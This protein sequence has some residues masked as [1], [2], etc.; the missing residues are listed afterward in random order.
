MSA[1]SITV[2]VPSYRRPEALER[3][4]A[5]LAEQRLQ[6]LE[7][8]VV[9]RAEDAASHAVVQA[10]PGEPRIVTVQVPGMVAA[11]NAGRAAASGSLIA[12]TDDD[13]EPH[14]DWLERIA[15]RFASD[16]RIGAVGGRDVV[17]HGERIDDGVARQVGRVRWWGRRV[18]AHHHRSTLQDVDFLKGANMSYRAAALEPFDARLH[19]AGAQVCNDL[20]ASL[21][22][23]RRGWRVVYDPAVLVEHRPAERFDEDGRTHRTLAAECAEQH[24][25]LYV[26]LRH[27]S[28]LGRVPL[29]AYHLLV[30]SRHAPGLALGATRWLRG[31][32]PGG[33]RRL[34]AL[35]RA[36]TQ[37][38]TTLRRAGRATGGAPPPDLISEKKLTN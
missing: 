24:N 13:C 1:D 10:A 14:A 5:A 4:L 28:T 7:T 27:S 11:L 31:R 37:A 2:V 25:E 18:G 34:G 22:I 23:A 8:L 17:H 3:C 33:L 9:L 38:L 20:E 16:A 29:L 36:R 12:F 35:V 32:E 19:G 6:P 15:A 30:G 21:S 26:L